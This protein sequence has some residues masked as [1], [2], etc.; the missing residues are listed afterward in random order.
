MHDE[1]NNVT[2]TNIATDDGPKTEIKVAKSGLAH[3]FDVKVKEIM[4][5]LT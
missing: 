1:S 5:K 3:A 2:V 4:K